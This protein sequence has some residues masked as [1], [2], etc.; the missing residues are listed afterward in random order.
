MIWAKL[1]QITHQ[2][3][4]HL[5]WFLVQQLSVGIINEPSQGTAHTTRGPFGKEHQFLFVFF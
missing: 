3:L 1:A 5:K 2:L 4:K